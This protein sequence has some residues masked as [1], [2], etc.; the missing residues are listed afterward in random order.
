M[1]IAQHAMMARKALMQHPAASTGK[2][3]KARVGARVFNPAIAAHIFA[4]MPP[5]IKQGCT[6]KTR[7]QV[8]QKISFVTGGSIEAIKKIW[9]G[10]SHKNASLDAMSLGYD[11]VKAFAARCDLLDEP[12]LIRIL[13]S[14]K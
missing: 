2:A 12:Y 8:A 7:S 3:T 5:E 10:L 14:L 9:T 6:D 4:V 11:D 13:Q 1:N